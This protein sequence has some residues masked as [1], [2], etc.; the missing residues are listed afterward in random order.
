[1]IF[2][3]ARKEFLNNLLSARFIIGFLLCLILIPFSILLNI[4]G[5]REQTRLYQ[6]SRDAAEKSEKEIRV[7]SALRPTVVFPPEPLSIFNKGLSGQMGNQVRI[8][9][10]EKPL[11]PE[12]RLATRDNP[13]LAAFFSV[14]FVDIAVI[15]FS[16]L[17][18]LFSYDALSREKEDGTLRQQMANALG[19]P[20]LLAGKVA[21][22]ILTLLPVLIFCFLLG[23]V[24]IL[25]SGHIAFSSGDWGR[26]ALLAVISLVYLIL[27]VFLGL[28]ISAR[29]KSS[30]TS[31]VVCLFLWV[32]L[33]FIVP[34]M[35]S[36]LAESFVGAPSRDALTLAL[37]DLNKTAG[38]RIEDASKNLPGT[39]WEMSWYMNSGEDGYAE[40]YGCS[41]SFFERERQRK[42]IAEP[43]RLDNADAKWGP[44][45]AYLDGLARQAMAA[46][47]LACLSP[48]GIFRIAASAVCGTDRR[49]YEK[50]MDD[51]RRYR[52]TFIRY[53]QGKS[54]FSSFAYFTPVPP[55]EFKPADHLVSAR[56]GGRF[57]TL[58][59]YDAWAEKQSDF[60]ARWQVLWT[61]AV[62]G[63]KPED[64]PFLV[65]SDLPRFSH[66]SASLTG[67]FEGTAL[68]NGFLLFES[69]FLFALG[70]VSFLR[71]D[72]R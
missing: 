10:G 58:A 64:H 48:A 68:F 60:R 19:R 63:E 45:K 56:T 37:R 41:A 69:V 72:V 49:A 1:M 65:V 18:L 15:I 46:D 21:G 50:K 59:E 6:L 66:R 38:K 33:V 12:G 11:L 29:T 42:A 57:K 28:L 71:Y 25:A 54:L 51:V 5:Y 17:A 24:L 20:K 27:F 35:S 23:A 32:F 43:M 52:E 7:Y 61:V 70:Y 36:Y 40:M 34:N 67:G 47:R 4:D 62:P 3:I 22:I 55:S 13:F 31:L 9:L 16:L 26:L 39:D 14:D 53:L 2:Q 8:R 30:V 44:Q